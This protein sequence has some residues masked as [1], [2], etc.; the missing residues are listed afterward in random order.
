[1]CNEN[2]TSYAEKEIENLRSIYSKC[3]TRFSILA[4]TRLYIFCS[5]LARVRHRK[6]H[7]IQITRNTIRPTMRLLALHLHGS[8]HLQERYALGK[9]YFLPRLPC[10]AIGQNWFDY[11]Y[12]S[13]RS[14]SF[15]F[16]WIQ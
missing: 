9:G 16:Q 2:R 10:G 11:Y 14:T 5:S 12:Y 4:H 1:M 7:T 3:C 15:M 6:N 13:Y 8:L